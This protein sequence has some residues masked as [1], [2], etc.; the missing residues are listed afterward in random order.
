M[1]RR[2]TIMAA[3]F[4]AVCTPCRGEVVQSVR[5][6]LAAA[7]EAWRQADMDAAVAELKKALAADSQDADA[8]AWMA[9][10]LRR[11]GKYGDALAEARLALAVAPDHAMALAVMGDLLNPQ[12]TGDADIQ[13]RDECIRLYRAALTSDP[14]DP[15]GLMGL[16]VWAIRMGDTVTGT[17]CLTAMTEAGLWTDPL[18][19]L[20]RWMLDSAPPRAILLLNGDADSFPVW[21]LQDQGIRPDV[22]ACNLS[23]LN[24]DD[25]RSRLALAGLPVPPDHLQHQRN[26]DGGVHTIAMQ[27]LGYLEQRARDGALDRPLAYATTVHTGNLPEGLP[28]HSHLRGGVF[29]YDPEDRIM[30]ID[31]EET[32]RTM[33]MVPPELMAGAWVSARERSPVRLKGNPYFRFN[34]MVVADRGFQKATIMRDRSAADWYRDLYMAYRENL[35][36]FN[37]DAQFNETD[38]EYQEWTR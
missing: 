1:L 7:H 37:G 6:H 28:H 12:F 29:V 27:V 35:G 25:Y 24:L 15:Q 19:A 36:S 33:A 30:L 16:C 11:Q 38:A 9:E 3:L 13:D 32:R 23:L 4:L 14:Y 21:I 5:V 10:A 18:M 26:P 2:I 8:H 34:P 31:L 22:L 20:A 17:A